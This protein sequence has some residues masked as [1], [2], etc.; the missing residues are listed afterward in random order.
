MYEEI[1]QTTIKNAI[2][3]YEENEPRGEFVLV[4]EGKEK[5]KGDE[6]LNNLPLKEHIN[7]YINQGMQKKDALKSV[8]K[9]RGVSKRD[10]YNADLE[11][12]ELD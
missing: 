1:K 8:A 4:I 12:K 10:V 11:G 2:S 6:L 3:Y 7:Y 9:D 5:I